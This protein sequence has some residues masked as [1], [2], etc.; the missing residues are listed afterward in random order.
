[1]II[2]CFTEISRRRDWLIKLKIADSLDDKL[3][4]LQG[5]FII[6]GQPDQALRI[7]VAVLQDS[8]VMLVGI[9]IRFMQR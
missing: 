4:F 6:H 7:P 2:G 9:E 8:S 5:Q 3:A 1:M